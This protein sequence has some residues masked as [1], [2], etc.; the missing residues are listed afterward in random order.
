MSSYT[1][2]A[3]TFRD[4][5]IF[6]H[7]L[8]QICREELVAVILH[9]PIAHQPF[10]WAS[11]A[12]NL[13]IVLQDARLELLQE[14]RPLLQ[15][16]WRSHRLSVQCLGY[17]ELLDAGS[18][19]ALPLARMRQAYSCLWGEDLLQDVNIPWEHLRLAIEQQARE[20]LLWFRQ[21]YVRDSLHLASFRAFL[22]QAVHKLELLAKDNQLLGINTQTPDDLL[23]STF[24]LPPSFLATLNHLDKASEAA[25]TC[26]ATTLEDE[27]TALAGRLNHLSAPCD[28]ALVV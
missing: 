28:E 18:A 15:R 21:T 4:T 16:W 19:L 26:L 5:D 20:V 9:V 6:L 17:W 10:T 11:G 14:L 27:L 2:S 8:R 3:S 7:E 22:A 24:H 12:H 13:L 23:A 25:L 1:V